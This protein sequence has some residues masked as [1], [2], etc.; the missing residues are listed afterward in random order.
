MLSGEL[1]VHTKAHMEL[2]DITG[3]VEQ[4]IA[5]QGITDG[6]LTLFTPHTTAGITINEGADPH[7]KE[8]LVGAL[9]HMVPMAYPYR[10]MEGNSPSHLMAMLTGS[11]V[12]VAMKN[13]R[14][15]LGTW[16]RIF[17]CEYD[18]PRHRRLEWHCIATA[19]NDAA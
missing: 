3:K 16:Q 6:L 4:A 7:V 10:H 9:K 12:T 1:A 15:L 18:G 8:D 11:S 5:V 2:V 19:E 13:G 14:L 17:F